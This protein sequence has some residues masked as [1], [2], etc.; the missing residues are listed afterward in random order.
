MSYAD[1]LFVEMCEDILATGVST[2]GENVRPVWEDN[3]APAYTIKKFGVVHRYDLRKE[4]P[5]LTLRPV[6]IK[7]AIN[8]IRWI[9]QKKSNDINDLKPHIW[10]SWA[11]EDGSIGKAYGYQVGKTHLH[12]TADLKKDEFII[13]SVPSISLSKVTF[14]DS[15]KIRLDQMD[16][17]LFDLKNHP[18]SRRMIITLWDPSELWEM[19]LQPCC[20]N[21]TF[22]VT[23]ENGELVLNMILNQRSN[24]ILAANAWNV[25]QYAAL[26]MMVA[27]HVNM[28]P[29]EF[30]HVIADAH[31]YDRHIDTV[32]E[33]ITREQFPAPKVSI[34]PSKTNFYDITEDDFII[35]NYQHGD[36]IGKID[37]A[38]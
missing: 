2:L 15:L 17:V 19:N 24:D 22:N 4:F 5:A 12:Y 9:Y 30:V 33:L 38:V 21:C 29:G 37:V 16:A 36:P 31:I 10:D 32:K 7:S 34:D 14:D 1:K 23:R 8:E 27:R 20:W 18:F 28:I 26:L 11:D 25:V 3:N 35:E 13:P 6:G